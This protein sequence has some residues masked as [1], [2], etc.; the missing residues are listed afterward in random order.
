MVLSYAR[1]NPQFGAALS[2]LVGKGFRSGR[3]LDVAVDD[4]TVGRIADAVYEAIDV[5]ERLV[6]KRD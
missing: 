3:A 6:E 1:E 2:S 4:E 5:Y